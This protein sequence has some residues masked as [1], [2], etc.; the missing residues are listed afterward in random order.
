M[1]IE[2]SGYTKLSG[3]GT[4]NNGSADAPII[5]A[6]SG[7]SIRLSRGYVAV[8]TAAVGGGGKVALE[9]SANGTRIWEADAN[10]IG[11]YLVNF[12]DIGYPLAVGNLLNLTVDGALTTQATARASLVGYA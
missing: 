10:A 3:T 6:V 7:K 5:A 11:H 4:V 8:T 9:D 1:G 12:G 2:L